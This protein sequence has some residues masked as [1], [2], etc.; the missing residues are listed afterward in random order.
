MNPEQA[1]ITAYG[2]IALLLWGYAVRIWLVR[3]G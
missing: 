1:V 3:K 2:L